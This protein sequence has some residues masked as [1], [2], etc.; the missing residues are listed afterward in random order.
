MGCGGLGLNAIAIARAMGFD[1]IIGI[2]IDN[3][4]LDAAHKMGA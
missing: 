1:N 4:K 3:S 2:D